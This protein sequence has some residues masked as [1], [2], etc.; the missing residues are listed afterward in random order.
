MKLFASCDSGYLRAH[1]PALVASAACADTSLHLNVISPKDED[2]DF[3]DHLSSRYHSIAGWPQSDFTY[4]T[5]PQWA[6]G[7]QIWGDALRTVW[8]TDRFL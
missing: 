7:S 2:H 4:S 8:A 1:A 5:A 6:T 3:L